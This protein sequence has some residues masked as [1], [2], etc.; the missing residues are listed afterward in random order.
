MEANA[1]LAVAVGLALLAIGIAVVVV[2]VLIALR[3]DADFGGEIK[4]PW[5]SLHIRLTKPRSGSQDSEDSTT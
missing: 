3:Q 1:P 4:A 5:F 2:L